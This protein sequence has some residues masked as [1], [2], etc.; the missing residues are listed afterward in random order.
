MF[1]VQVSLGP[2]VHCSRLPFRGLGFRVYTLSY[3]GPFRLGV[4]GV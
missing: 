4:R 1:R 3:K 2:K